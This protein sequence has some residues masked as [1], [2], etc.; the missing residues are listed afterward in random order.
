MN[1]NGGHAEFVKVPS[2]WAIRTPDA[3]SNKDIMIYGTAGLTAALSINELLNN[4]LEEHSNI[5][6]TG[7]TGGVGSI[8]VAILSKLGFK[9]SALT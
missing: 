1:T 9:V 2:S 3:I 6:V 5:L 8:T 4:G 7:S